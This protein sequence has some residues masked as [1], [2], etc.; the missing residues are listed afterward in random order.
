M[1]GNI[2]RL[3]KYNRKT[4]KRSPE[5]ISI[6]KHHYPTGQEQFTLTCKYYHFLN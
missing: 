4:D 1:A 5:T 2:K 6:T 3:K